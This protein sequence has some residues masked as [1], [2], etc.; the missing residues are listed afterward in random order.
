MLDALRTRDTC[1]VHENRDRTQFRIRPLNQTLDLG[2]PTDIGLHRNGTPAQRAHH[3]RNRL[4]L[5]S[6]RPIVDHNMR[7]RPRQR[8]RNRAP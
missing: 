6:A 1:I 3:L 2:R 5:L 7:A 8:D 4:C